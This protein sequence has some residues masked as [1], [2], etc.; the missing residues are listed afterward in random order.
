MAVAVV[1]T[2]A[3]RLL[4]RARDDA[5]RLARVGFTMLLGVDG[6]AE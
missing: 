5:F 3:N 4:L 1:A 6:I 2:M